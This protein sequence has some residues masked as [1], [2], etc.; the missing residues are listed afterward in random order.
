MSYL[1]TTKSKKMYSDR[2]YLLH[3]GEFNYLLP[4]IKKQL[5]QSNGMFYVMVNS[6]NSDDLLNRLKGYYD[7]FDEIPYKV[8]RSVFRDRSLT[9]FRDFVKQ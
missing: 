3:E 4:A 8:C 2:S 7:Y 5:S 1:C 9:A 6:D